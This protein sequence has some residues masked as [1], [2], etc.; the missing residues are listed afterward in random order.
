MKFLKTFKKSFSNLKENIIIIITKTSFFPGHIL[1]VKK[2]IQSD[3]CSQ[4]TYLS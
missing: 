3:A 4:A 2:V 1:C